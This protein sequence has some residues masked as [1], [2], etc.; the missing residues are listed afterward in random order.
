[1][2]ILVLDIIALIADGIM[3]IVDSKK[4]VTDIKTYKKKK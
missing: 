1:M 3:T 2:F 4:L